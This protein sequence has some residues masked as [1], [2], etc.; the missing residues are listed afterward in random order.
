MQ[1]GLAEPEAPDPGQ[2]ERAARHAMPP[3]DRAGFI[4][5]S[6]VQVLIDRLVA[7]ATAIE[8][9]PEAAAALARV[10][11]A[12]HDGRAEMVAGV[13][14]DAIPFE[15][16]AEHGFVAAAMQVHF[17]RLA[18]Q[19]DPKSLAPVGD[20]VCPACGGA[21]SATLVVGWKRADGTRFCSCA[22]C[23]TLWNYVRAKCTLCGSTSN[24][25]LREVA[26]SD[27]T[28]KAEVCGDC[29]GYVK[30]LYQQKNPELDPIADDVASLALDLLMRETDVRRGAVNPFLAGY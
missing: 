15:G 20:G 17:A 14:V 21:P 29:R 22:L 19:L 9:P 6:D 18:A 24:I 25:S 26:G 10:A 8:M 5:G 2:L 13:L 28:I 16:I 7:A 12:G 11:G 3:L 30:V 1:E 23:G 4:A 27:G